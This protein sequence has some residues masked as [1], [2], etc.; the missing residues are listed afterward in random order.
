MSQQSM[1]AHSP[2]QQAQ[3]HA[4]LSSLMQA[5]TASG[6]QVALF[7]THISW[8]I[9]TPATAWKFKKAVRLDILDFTTLE[10]RRACCLE[11]LR[12]NRRLAGEL[13]LGLSAVIGSAQAPQLVD[14]DG[15]TEPALDYA[16][17]MRTFPQEALWDH[18]AQQGLLG[19]D[20]AAGLG[21]LLGQFQLDAAVASADSEFGDP[22]RLLAVSRSNRHEIAALLGDVTAHQQLEQVS[23]ALELLHATLSPLRLARK[24]EGRV[25]ECHGDLHC[26]NLLTLDGRSLA[27]DCIEF[28][29]VLRWIDVI[30][31]IAFAVMDLRMFGQDKIAACLLDAWLQVTG[32]YGGLRLLNASMAERALVRCKVGLLRARQ[33][34]PDA[35]QVAR[36]EAL[37]YLA[38]A[39]QCLHP[40]SGRIIITHGFS[41]CGKSTVA[42]ALARAM[43]ALRLRSDIERKR[44]L[45]VAP[46]QRPAAAQRATL[47]ADSAREQVYVHLTEQA[48]HIVRCGMT[49][50]VDAAFLQ[51]G[52]RELLRSL[53]GDLQVPM[54]ILDCRTDLALLRERLA[55]RIREGRDPS[56]A[57]LDVL[58]G[59]LA[60]HDVLTAT[61]LRETVIVHTGRELPEEAA[62]RVAALVEASQ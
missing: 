10:A 54:L 6:E 14:A 52:Q 55:V 56:D 40:Q 57:D 37:A 30:D 11:E 45:G 36:A 1:A 39:W 32:D 8:V 2:W 33:Q 46:G 4:A 26:S 22:A 38:L 60:R 35:A 42:A 48:A 53:A 21:Q 61:E 17:R 7:E 20:E 3:Q 49:V 31:D 41:G 29:P 58:A 27:F 34:S 9:V 62:R 19:F 18:R 50:I 51:H 59:Q 23:A 43:G 28:N 13:Y 47:Y 25:R 16:V 12:L 15:C 24:R 44:L 5:M